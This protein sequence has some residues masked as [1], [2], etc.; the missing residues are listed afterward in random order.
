MLGL[1]VLFFWGGALL[2]GFKQKKERIGFTFEETLSAA[3]RRIGGGGGVRGQLWKWGD[4][5]E[6]PVIIQVRG[7]GGSQQV[8][9]AGG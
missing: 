8:L 5:K 1:F 7:A 2:G 6:L 3:V 9:E 4:D